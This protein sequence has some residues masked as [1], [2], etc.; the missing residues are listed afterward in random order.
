MPAR[1]RFKTSVIDRERARPE[2][3]M[4][5]RVTRRR[6]T[7]VMER[8]PRSDV[9]NSAVAPLWAVD[10]K[11]PLSAR[12]PNTAVA[13]IPAI[14]TPVAAP[15]ALDPAVTGAAAGFPEV[16][17]V[18]VVE[19]GMAVTSRGAA[20][21]TFCD[22][23]PSAALAVTFGSV[24][25][26]VVVVTFR[27]VVPGTGVVPTTVVVT[28]VVGTTVV[29]TLGTVVVTPGTV[30]VIFGSVVVTGTVVVTFG[31]V[32]V[33]W[34]SVVVTG[35]VVVTFGTVVVTSGTV[36]VTGGRTVVS[37]SVVVRFG[38][39]VP[40]SDVEIRS[41]TEP[42]AT[43]TPNKPPRARRRKPA[44]ALRTKPT[45]L[46]SPTAPRLLLVVVGIPSK[47]GKFRPREKKEGVPANG[48]DAPAAPVRW[49]LGQVRSAPKSGAPLEPGGRR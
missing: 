46:I 26:E 10:E 35:R 1:G 2:S 43:A 49:P 39:V 16:T 30:V 42:S 12:G 17:D 20:V 9:R 11:A 7:H 48:T 32:V 4:N 45:W 23:V 18:V 8:A 5:E 21:V 22:V 27:D 34:G 31:T 19:L 13:G 37:G 41:L 38:T 47:E 25:A 15:S 28:T 40:G 33:I 24:E 29:V 44:A 14:P 3:V 36:V 6:L